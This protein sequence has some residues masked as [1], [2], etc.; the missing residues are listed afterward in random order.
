MIWWVENPARSAQERL[1]IDTLA[2]SVDWLHPIGLRLDGSHLCWDADIVTNERT[3][4]VTLRYPDHFPNSPPLVLPRGEQERWSSHQY[5]AGGELC[6]EFGPDNWHP[7]LTGADMLQSAYNL[8]T[9]EEQLSLG[10]PDVASRHKDSLGQRL[11]TLPNRIFITSD[12]QD[13]LIGLRENA[14]IPG[15]VVAI[16][17]KGAVTFV[18]A[19][20]GE[21]N[22]QWN[23]QLPPAML[24]SNMIFDAKLIRW[25]ANVELPQS[26]DATALREE[27]QRAGVDTNGGD[28]LLVIK[29][30]TVS[31]FDLAFSTKAKRLAVVLEP[32]SPSR[33]DHDHIVLAERKVAIIGCGSLGS[34]IAAMLARS[35]VEKFVLVD[36]DILL[37]ENL[38]RNDLDWREVTMH[39]VDA[40]SEKVQYIRPGALCERYKRSLGGQES[41]RNVETLMEVLATCD[42]LVDATAASTAFNYLSSVATFA[43]RTLIW[44]EVFG[45]G[46]GGFVARSRPDLEPDP[47][48]M[49]QSILHWS[50]EQGQL[51]GRPQ[52]RY[53]GDEENPAIANDAEVSVIAAHMALSAIDTLLP[54]T[55][56]AY[57]FGVYMIGLRAGWI[58]DQPFETRPIDVGPPQEATGI[59]YSDEEKRAEIERVLKLIGEYPN[60]NTSAS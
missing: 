15:T 37:P 40:L 8:L 32:S 45:G 4:P 43:R 13:M 2:G 7:D 52:G 9:G 23:A 41:S 19:S 21:S 11:R 31:A 5:G 59:I 16:F 38:V 60:A 55:P 51:V 56:S 46:Y 20:A 53:E 6:L 34:K 14:M 42:L 29:D 25:P 24:T 18:L 48:T 22:S 28:L 39:K 1:V 17:R 26:E 36:D 30:A 33:L 58:F 54:R 57:P 12:G 27:F 49:R 35:G 10:G 47:A 50:N 3:Y 44:G